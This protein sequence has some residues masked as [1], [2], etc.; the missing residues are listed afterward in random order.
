[1]YYDFN[2]DDIENSADFETFIASL[3]NGLKLSVS[4]EEFA[5]MG[6]EIILPEEEE[7]EVIIEFSWPSGDVY[8]FMKEED[9]NAMSQYLVKSIDELNTIYASLDFPLINVET[10]M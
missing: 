7:D 6:G 8:F 1:M 9:E 10:Q 3:E 2:E 5:E 4:K